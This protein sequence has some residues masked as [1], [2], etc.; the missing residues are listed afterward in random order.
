MMPKDK[1]KNLVQKT[2]GFPAELTRYFLGEELYDEWVEAQSKLRALTKRIQ[3]FVEDN[4]FTSVVAQSVS[5]KETYD[6][7]MVVHPHLGHVLIQFMVDESYYTYLKKS[8]LYKIG[9]EPK[10]AVNFDYDDVLQDTVERQKLATGG[11]PSLQWLR[12]EASILGLKVDYLGQKRRGIADLIR[13]VQLHG[14]VPSHYPYDWVPPNVD[15]EA[16]EEFLEEIDRPVTAMLEAQREYQEEQ[17]AEPEPITQI[18]L[19]GRVM[20]VLEV[21]VVEVSDP[22]AEL[23]PSRGSGRKPVD[24]S[25]LATGGD[26]SSQPNS[27]KPP[28]KIEEREVVMPKT[29]FMDRMMADSTFDLESIM[30]E[31]EEGED[32]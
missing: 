26:S 27:P 25:L 5:P 21:E 7:T 3:Q 2:E 16:Y 4:P 20:E 11:L 8:N 24:L 32:E 14:K 30:N 13:F 10:D 22:T 12:T 6:H 31:P 17:A 18:E 1:E 28:P 15:A 23:S 29:N 9:L 19:N